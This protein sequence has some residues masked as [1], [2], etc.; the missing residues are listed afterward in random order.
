MRQFETPGFFVGFFGLFCQ[1]SYTPD[2]FVSVLERMM[3][4]LKTGKYIYKLDHVHI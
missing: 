4:G 2:G 1:Q 3:C